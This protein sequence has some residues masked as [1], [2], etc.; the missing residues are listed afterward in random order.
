MS[1]SFVERPRHS[2]NV[3]LKCHHYFSNW[4]LFLYN[5]INS[6]MH[7]KRRRVNSNAQ[8]MLNFSR[9]SILYSLELN[10]CQLWIIARARRDEKLS[11]RRKSS[12]NFSLFSQVKTESVPRGQVHV[13]VPNLS[14]TPLPRTPITSLCLDNVQTFKQ[15]KL[16]R[17]GSEMRVLWMTV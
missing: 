11:F 6:N 17:K 8:D 7:P 14:F 5:K 2:C 9:S 13:G 10:L 3:F 1:S 16:I 4:F 12:F 15:L